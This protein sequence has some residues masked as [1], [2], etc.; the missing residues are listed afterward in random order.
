M[1]NGWESRRGKENERRRRKVVAKEE[2]RRK[3]EGER[4]GKG[5]ERLVRKI[6]SYGPNPSSPS[7]C[8]TGSI[9]VCSL[10]PRLLVGGEKRAWYLLFAHARNYPLLNMCLGKSG[11]RVILIHVIDSATYNLAV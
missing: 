4:E 11:K 7:L 10:V 9:R 2:G 1:G 8:D 5:E 6:C 3:R